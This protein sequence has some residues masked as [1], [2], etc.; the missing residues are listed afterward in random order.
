[1]NADLVFDE[2]IL[3]ELVDEVGSVV[4]VDKGLFQDES[5]KLVV[6]QDG[7]I[8][9][10]SKKIEQEKSYG[11]SIDVY[12]FDKQST[13]V[14]KH[15]VVKII[16][17][18]EDLNQWTEVLLDKVFSERLVYA[19]PL[20]IKGKKWYEIDNYEDLSKA[21]ILFNEKLKLINKK[22]AFIL[23]KDGTLT[24]IGRASCR[25]RV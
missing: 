10:I 3:R 20:D 21:E 13:K 17:E 8:Q 6:D 5:M 11:C 2:E 12:K 4:A 16:E 19:K 15:E 7:Y 1:M 14:L 22:K 18:E 9:N 23:D 24:K 25:E